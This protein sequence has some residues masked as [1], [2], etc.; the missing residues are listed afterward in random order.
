MPGQ[1]RPKM[2]VHELVS[3]VRSTRNTRS[4]PSGELSGSH[5]GSGSSTHVRT[6]SRGSSVD[7]GTGTTLRARI[8]STRRLDAAVEPR[9]SMSEQSTPEPEQAVS[10]QGVPEQPESGREPSS[11]AERPSRRKVPLWVW[12]VVAVV[13]L[14]GAVAG[15]LA[16]TGAFTPEALPTPPAETVTAT[17][18]TP[19]VE[20]V[21]REGEPTAFSAALP[22][23]V[24]DLALADFSPGGLFD[25][26][27][28]LE[29]YTLVYSD[30]GSRTVTVY[31]AQ[32]PDA[33][34][35]AAGWPDLVT[36]EI[37]QGEVTAGGTVVGEWA[38]AG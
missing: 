8:A 24:L 35:T 23:T 28:P 6:G 31:A 37:E 15:I 19:T 34:A 27:K 12:F 11:G 10:E 38:F 32:F 2:H 3:H 4:G 1:P 25:D 7:D 30:G 9:R 5:S 29:S 20:P 36:D 13:V 17:P 22:D 33:E 26:A 18:P 21:A 14:G 16:G